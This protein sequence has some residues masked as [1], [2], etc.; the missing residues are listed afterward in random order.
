MT[1][2]KSSRALLSVVLAVLMVAAFMPALTYSSFA[3]TAKKATKVTKLNHT[4]AKVYGKVGN[5]YVLK[6]KL[7]PSKLTSAAK[8]TVWKSSDSSI[9]KVYSTKG[10][11]A[12]VKV[13]GV[14]TA[15]ITVYTKANTK[16]KAVWSFKTKEDKTT[17]TGVTVSAPNAKDPATDLKVGTTLQAK[18]APEA[19]DVT[20]QWYAD[21]AKIDGATSSEFTVTT[22]QI[23]KAITVK[24]ASKNEVESAA[25]AKVSAVKVT[26][27]VMKKANSEGKYEDSFSNGAVANAGDSFQLQATTLDGVNS[28]SDA[29]D[30]QWYRNSQ[31]ANGSAV[32]TP[33]AGATTDTYT[34]TK[35]DIGYTVTA[36]VTPKTGVTVAGNAKG[37]NETAYTIATIGSASKKITGTVSAV[38]K[39][40][41]K[42]VENATAGATLTAEVTPADATVTYQWYKDG[43]KLD[44]ATSAT[45]TAKDKGAYTVKVSVASTEKTYSGTSV[46]ASNT[47][48]VGGDVVG[49][50]TL[51]LADTKNLLTDAEESQ[52]TYAGETLTA[53]AQK[54]GGT[55][56]TGVQYKWYKNGVEIKDAKTSTYTVPADTA[57][58]DTFYAEVSSGGTTVKTNTLTAKA[59]LTV[60]PKVAGSDKT[61]T[62][63]LAKPSDA[64][65]G[66]AYTATVKVDIYDAQDNYV[67]STNIDVT[68][69]DNNGVAT[70]E[71]GSGIVNQ[72]K[73]DYTVK[74]RVIVKGVG[75]YIASAESKTASGSVTVDS[76]SNNVTFGW[77]NPESAEG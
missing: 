43:V 65:L 67:S 42:K 54:M 49:A 37:A 76:T 34:L 13:K 28:L 74:A 66:T 56:T 16:A 4:G 68:S 33:I 22:D 55:I 48:N 15:K 20:Y 7:S 46:Q 60:S 75:N 72:L 40:D 11:H 64:V 23:G 62:V 14:G 52:F 9:V 27:I 39:V 10:K 30:I 45:Y 41:G 2:T 47:V 63:T 38:I 35:D 57:A 25:T 77:T 58:G 32:E 8:K 36:K 5:K 71:L 59:A 73:A 1:R 53:E 44:G 29:V 19:K 26:N 51:K 18:A 21:G 31:S 24:A 61:L 50:A 70:V 17:L 3:A 12:A 6:Y 69:V